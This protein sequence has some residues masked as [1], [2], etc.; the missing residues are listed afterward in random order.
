M[1]VLLIYSDRCK[2]CKKLESYDIFNKIDKLN[3][4]NKSELSQ[5]PQY[6]KTVPTLI[7]KKN[8]KITILKDNELLQWIKINS[9]NADSAYNNIEKTETVNECNTLVNTKF[10]SEYAFI[11]SSA[12][13]LLENFYSNIESNNLIN[14]PQTGGS[15]TRDN[16]SLDTDYEALMKRRS[17]DFKPIERH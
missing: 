13:N 4:S 15:N 9:N 11:D 17:E 5:M 7:I 3:I 14:T 12:D 1:E 2:N 8:E 10:S 16:K 6:V